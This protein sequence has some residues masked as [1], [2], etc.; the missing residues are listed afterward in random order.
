MKGSNRAN[1][2]KNIASVKVVDAYT[3]ELT[4][5]KPYAPLLSI[6]AD[7]AGMMRSPAAVKK[8]GDKFMNSPVGSVPINL[9]KESR[10]IRLFW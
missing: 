2:L 3:V 7:R 9:K 4:M 8:L 6:L 5:K 10:A 1:E